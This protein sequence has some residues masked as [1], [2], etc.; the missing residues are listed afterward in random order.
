MNTNDK[1]CSFQLY[2]NGSKVCYFT[3]WYNI[4]TANEGITTQCKSIF[5]NLAV[6]NT[7]ECILDLEGVLPLGVVTTILAMLHSKLSEL[8]QDI[9]LHNQGLLQ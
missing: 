6:G 3:A 9:L 8:L 2:Q 4:G 5:L 7:L 1:A